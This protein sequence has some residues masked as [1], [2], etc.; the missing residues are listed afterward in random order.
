MERRHRPRVGAL[1]AIL[2]AGSC[3][4]SSH[5]DGTGSP[6]PHS[7]ALVSRALG[8]ADRLAREPVLWDR[9]ST[10]GSTPIAS[11]EGGPRP[12]G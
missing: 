12:I 6:A 11:V 10:T 9:R 1:V 5:T 4:A 8:T 3:T 2:V 7:S